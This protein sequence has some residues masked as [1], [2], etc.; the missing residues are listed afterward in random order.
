LVRVRERK[1]VSCDTMGL[2]EILPPAV[3]KVLQL[4]ISSGGKP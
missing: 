2:P 3:A 1:A 4:I